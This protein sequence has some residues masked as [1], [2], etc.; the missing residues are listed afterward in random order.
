MESE[1]H[2]AVSRPKC[3]QDWEGQKTTILELRNCNHLAELMK[4][5]EEE[6]LFKATYVPIGLRQRLPCLDYE[7]YESIQKTIQK[8]GVR[9][10]A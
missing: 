6:H 2:R 7:Q 4:R 10:S 8:M 9:S 5:M 1:Q 3:A